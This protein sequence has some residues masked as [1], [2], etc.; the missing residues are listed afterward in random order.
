VAATLRYIPYSRAFLSG[1][2]A[3]F[4]WQLCRSFLSAG[5]RGAIRSITGVFPRYS[6]EAKLRQQ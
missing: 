4:H 1:F 6:H 2:G 3:A 5:R